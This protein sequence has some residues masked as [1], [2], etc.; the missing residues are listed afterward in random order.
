MSVSARLFWQDG[1]FHDDELHCGIGPS[2]LGAQCAVALMSGRELTSSGYLVNYAIEMMRMTGRTGRFY[3]YIQDTEDHAFDE[4]VPTPH[5]IG[6]A[7]KCKAVARQYRQTVAFVASTLPGLI[8]TR[9]LILHAEELEQYASELTASARRCE[10]RRPLAHRYSLPKIRRSRRVGAED[11]IEYLRRAGVFSFNGYDASPKQLGRLIAITLMRG[12]NEV[13]VGGITVTVN[14]VVQML[15]DTGRY[16]M[17]TED[18]WDDRFDGNVP[19]CL[20]KR[21]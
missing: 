13:T 5:G 2:D 10:V 18:T 15:R 3:D 6:E 9:G 7:R 8:G 14:F 12:D 21:S 19:M 11:M 1:R 4:N 20:R 17:F 16:G